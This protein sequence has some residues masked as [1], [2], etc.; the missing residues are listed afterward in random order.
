MFCF[1]KVA[2]LPIRRKILHNNVAQ[3][4]AQEKGLRLTR[5][6]GM[7]KARG[8]DGKT[9]RKGALAMKSRL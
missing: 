3:G 7:K 8:G 9:G 1:G 6:V 4:Q 2:N 5:K